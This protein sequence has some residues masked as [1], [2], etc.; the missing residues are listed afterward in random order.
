MQHFTL[1]PVEYSDS[2]LETLTPYE[3]TATSKGYTAAPNLVFDAA[4][5]DTYWKSHSFTIDDLP[6]RVLD[7]SNYQGTAGKFYQNGS[8]LNSFDQLTPS[9]L[10]SIHDA[11][12]LETFL[13]PN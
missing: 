12:G 1:I 8:D 2:K 6:T 13:A 5:I 11:S 4:T 3:F 7:D 9:I 10:Q